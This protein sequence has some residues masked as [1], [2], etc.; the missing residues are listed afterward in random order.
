M[1]NTGSSEIIPTPQAANSYLSTAGGSRAATV[2]PVF[3]AVD[4]ELVK[5][6][7]ERALVYFIECDFPCVL[8]GFGIVF[9]VEKKIQRIT[10]SNQDYFTLT[11]ETQ[12][13]IDFEKTDET[14]QSH[15]AQFP[16]LLDERDISDRVFERV[17]SRLS[18]PCIESD[19]RKLLKKIITT[20]KDETV[21]HGFCEVLGEI[22]IFVAHHNRQGTTARDWFAGSDIFIDKPWAKTTKLES[23]AK[24]NL[25]TLDNAHEPFAMFY[26]EPQSKKTFHIKDELSA[27]GYEVPDDISEEFTISVGAFLNDSNKG[28][29]IVSFVSD[30]LRF[31]QKNRGD[32]SSG[33]EIVVQM[34]I[35]EIDAVSLNDSCELDISKFPK[36]LGQLFSLSALLICCSKSKQIPHEVA[37]ELDLDGLEECRLGELNT[38]IAFPYARLGQKQRDKDGTFY[39][40]VITLVTADEALMIKNGQKYLLSLFLN[41]KS[42]DQVASTRRKSVCRR[43]INNR[44][45]LAKKVIEPSQI[46]IK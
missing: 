17:Q 8:E 18:V 27:L 34:P 40:S 23:S 13:T 7:L 39:Y 3:S 2:I 35:A 20:I 37:V 1:A 15:R 38:M 25:P 31:L 45:A 11:V 14:Y 26:G 12:R 9:P 24:L 22:G 43:T 32:A 5:R 6:E 21:E 19:V 46:S 30:G 36:F 10:N 29:K 44:T 28:K 16:K 33:S 42:Y 41:R 4:R